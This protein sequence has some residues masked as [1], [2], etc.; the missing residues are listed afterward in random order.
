MLNRFQTTVLLDLLEDL[1]YEGR[2]DGL[3]VVGLLRSVKERLELLLETDRNARR[4]GRTRPPMTP[5]KSAHSHR[6]ARCT[7]VWDC[8]PGC[9]LALV[10]ASTDCPNCNLKTT[11]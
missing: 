1:A 4:A 6:C 10:A 3:D 11:D 8:L 2:P 5:R 9:R 7:H